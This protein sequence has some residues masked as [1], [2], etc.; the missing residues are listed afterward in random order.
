MLISIRVLR[1]FTA[2]I[3]VLIAG[4][5]AADAPM[6]RPD[7]V[8]LSGERLERV[9]ELVARHI[10]DGSFSGAVQRTHWTKVLK[11]L[12]TGRLKIGRT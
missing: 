1:T 7:N 9:N 2:L 3:A 8:G 12:W 11:T 6:A 4:G 5:A 10:D